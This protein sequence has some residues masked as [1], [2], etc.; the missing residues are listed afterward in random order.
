MT[1]SGLLTPNEL[2]VSRIAA[3]AIWRSSHQD[4][5]KHEPVSRPRHHKRH[6]PLRD[7]RFTLS[8][9]RSLRRIHRRLVQHLNRK[10][11]RP[12]RICV[13]HPRQLL[14]RVGRTLEIVV[15]VIPKGRSISA[16]AGKGVVGSGGAGHG[17]QVE[18][19]SYAG[20]VEPAEAA[21]LLE[22]G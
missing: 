19:G 15:L 22:V 16:F 11:A 10:Y 2:S 12:R 6:N 1:A 13:R 8:I 4:K 9:P 18:D 5:R 7:E 17:V 3:V 20:G 14:D 21:G